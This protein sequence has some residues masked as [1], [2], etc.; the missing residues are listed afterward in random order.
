M[1]KFPLTQKRLEHLKSK[2]YYPKSCLDLGSHVGEWTEM[3]KNVFP[4]SES[5]CIEGNPL[6]G[7]HLKKKGLPHIISL[8]GEEKKDDVDFYVDRNDCFS[9]GAS[10]YLENTSY[11]NDCYTV[12]LPMINIDSLGKQFDFIKMDVQGAELDTLKGGIKTIKK[13]D[14]LLLELSTVEYNHEAPLCNE[15]IKFLDNQGFAI[16]DIFELH[17]DTFFKRNNELLQIDFCFV[18]KKLKNKFIKKW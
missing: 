7:P 12:R 6:C 14:F 9:G 4:D 13:A 16:Y 15:V 18:N 17:Y 2:K 3:F 11:Y 8:V 5:L 10:I 1:L